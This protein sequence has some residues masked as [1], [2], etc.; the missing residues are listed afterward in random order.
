MPKK[1]IS[2]SGR[3]QSGKTFIA[4]LTVNYGYTLLNFADEI[5]NVVCKVI[6][7]DI[8]LLNNIKDIDLQKR[9]SFLSQFTFTKESILLMASLIDI[10][11]N[12]VQE[13][14]PINSKIISI[15]DVLQKLGTDLIRKYNPDWHVNKIRLKIQDDKKYVIPDTRFINE[16]NLIKEL[17][18]DYFFIIRPNNKDISNHISEVSLNW[19]HFNLDHVI[20]NNKDTNYLKENWNY[21]MKHDI[22]LFK[23]YPPNYSYINEAPKEEQKE[24]EDNPF[25]LENLKRWNSF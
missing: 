1:I 17:D 14:F 4:N 24:N 16:L 18:G 25:M 23:E 22:L 19:S 3:K 5:K 7:I 20:I 6:G 10:P 2:F 13:I 15:R 9:N 21:F 11:N 8:S 12:F